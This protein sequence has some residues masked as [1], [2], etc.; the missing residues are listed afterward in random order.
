VKASKLEVPGCCLPYTVNT[1]NKLKIYR[2]FAH[3]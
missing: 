1:E 2:L 3:M